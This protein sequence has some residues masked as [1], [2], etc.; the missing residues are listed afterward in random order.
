[1][2]AVAR[3]DGVARIVSQVKIIARILRGVTHPFIVGAHVTGNVEL[4]YL[5]PVVVGQALIAARHLL[6]TFVLRR[7]IVFH[8]LLTKDRLIE[9]IGAAAHSES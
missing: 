8:V 1:L 3:A 4:V 5:P 2:A 9:E 7:E 6:G